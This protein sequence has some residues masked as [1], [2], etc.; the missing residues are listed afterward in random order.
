MSDESDS[1]PQTTAL[2]DFQVEV[3]R[4]FFSLPASERFL[5][6]GGAALLAQHLTVRP[7][8]D[9]DFFTSTPGSVAVASGEFRA[10]VLSRGWAV[11]VRQSTDTFCRLVV[12]GSEDLLVDIALDSTPLQPATASFAGPTFA[13]EELAARKLLALF[14]RAEAR[15]FADVFVLAQAFDIAEMVRRAGDLDAGF[16]RVVLAEQVSRL[17]RFTDEEVPIDAD[18]IHELRAYFAQWTVDLRLDG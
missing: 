5:L 8:Q 2:T 1:G 4:L 13:P 17:D 10:A 11:D 12:H 14:D 9:L 16:D 6:A 3:A 15:D 18:Q 7:T